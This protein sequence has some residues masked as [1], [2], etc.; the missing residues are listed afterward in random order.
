[1]P[2]RVSG[3]HGGVVGRVTTEGMCMPTVSA[4]MPPSYLWMG[5]R[6]LTPQRPARMFPREDVRGAMG[7]AECEGARGTPGFGHGRRLQRRAS[8]PSE[9][10]SSRRRPSPGWPRSTK[11]PTD[12][13]GG[14]RA[15]ALPRA[16]ADGRRAWSSGTSTDI[17]ERPP[18]S[19]SSSAA[20]TAS[21]DLPGALAMLRIAVP[22]KG[23]LARPPPGC[24]V[25]RVTPSASRPRPVETTPT[26]SSFL[27]ASS[28]HRHLCRVR[29]SRL[30]H[31]PRC[32][33]R[34]RCRRR[35]GP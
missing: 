30:G 9:R 6:W 21:T 28:R 14:D 24:C 4:L 11:G 31:R 29:R 5:V 18:A 8:T 1:M 34:R 20:S 3:D 7:R 27:P 25:R 13:R 33:H 16:G 10:R 26:T 12:R 23:S 2:M 19:S 15:V 22:N 32:A 17:S 35:G